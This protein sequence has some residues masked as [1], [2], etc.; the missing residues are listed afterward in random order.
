[1]KVLKLTLFKKIFLVIFIGFFFVETINVYIDYQNN[2]ASIANNM[3]DKYI[4]DKLDLL[5]RKYEDKTYQATSSQIVESVEKLFKDQNGYCAVLDEQNQVIYETMKNENFSQKP[6]MVVVPKTDGYIDYIPVRINLDKLSQEQR[7][8][9]EK[10]IQNLD[11]D[12][13]IVVEYAGK[14]INVENGGEE[15]EPTYLSV[16]GQIYL[17][18][19]IQNRQ[20]S[21]V[22]IYSSPH[23]FYRDYYSSSNEEAYVM[24]DKE[25]SQILYQAA[26]KL[27]HDMG[28]VGMVKI[29]YEKM[30][31]NLVL[32]QRIY[33][34]LNDQ[35]TLS[36]V[37]VDYY[38]DVFTY[39]FSQA[40]YDNIKVYIFSLILSFLMSLGISYMV[41]RRIKKIDNI[42]RQIA[43]NHF[44]LSLS[45]K[46]RDEL[47]TLSH[48]INHMSQRLKLTIQQ[49]NDE[50]EHVKQ[51]E[52]VR[53]EFIANF[54]HEIKT[55]L[56]I[57]NGYIE[58]IEETKD[59]QKK[60]IYLEAINQETDKI[61]QL[62]LAMLDLSRLES[63]QVE[64]HIQELD[65]EDILTTIIE[66]FASL[67]EKKQ[68]Q[69]VMTGE[70]STIEADLFEMELVIKNLI[71]N[72]IKHTPQNGHIYICY[73]NQTLF[74]ENE[75]EH[76]SDK[77]K[78]KI[79]DTY[80]SSDREGTGLGLAICKTVL[81]LHGF[82]YDVHNTERGVSFQVNLKH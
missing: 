43:D 10:N 2:C 67:L 7:D 52:S 80:V 22:H 54:T 8:T 46:P 58:L 6:Y 68:I 23:L 21:C 48:N 74:I 15:I 61:N 17:E 76:L 14:T 75:G 69:V 47:G 79:W 38:F 5:A 57:I 27:N 41:T 65:L 29:D 16:D 9:I 56:A 26:L 55:P 45:E 33:I 32:T 12:Q 4:L 11:K 31:N 78:D 73:E 18:D 40:I 59:D 28:G 20:T 77:Q 49:L 60:S 82:S 1:M 19:K 24:N 70:Y 66:S 51:L 81:D 25:F 13:A 39:A 3:V 34:T 35:K 63:G 62:I 53:K 71:S 42:T 50:I 64:L 37:F 72:A 30:D 44:D 36:V